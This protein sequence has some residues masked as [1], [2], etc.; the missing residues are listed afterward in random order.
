MR[1]CAIMPKR[2]GGR[3]RFRARQP[4]FETM[5]VRILL[6]AVFWTG[7]AGDN[8]WDTPSNWSTDAV[9]G[10][11]DDVAINVAADVVHPE[12]VVDTVNSLN[13]NQP[14]TISAGTL[15]VTTT[16]T[17]SADLTISGGTLDGAGDMTVGGLLTLSSGTLSGSGTVTANGGIILNGNFTATDGKTL[18]NPAGQTAS[19]SGIYNQFTLLDGAVIINDGTF[20]VQSGEG[21]V[22]SDG[23]TGAPVAF[24]NNGAFLYN[25]SGQSFSLYNVPFNVTSPG[26]VEVQAGTLQIGAGG[27][28][29]TSSGGMFAADADGTL[30]FTGGT[31]S[32]DAS[33]SIGGPGAVGFA[34]TETIA[35]PYDVTGT[36]VFQGGT[37][38]FSG[39]IV[40][41][42][43]TVMALGG[44]ANLGANPIATTTLTIT[45]GTLNGSAD[46][47]VGG[48]TTFNGNGDISGSGTITA[49][50]GIV[51]TNGLATIDGKTLVNP[52][53]QTAS[54]TG[55]YDGFTLLDGAV[56]VNDGTFDGQTASGLVNSEGN[57][58]AP[59]A[60]T[61][62]GA[63]LYNDV[64][65]TFAI[66]NVLFNVTSTGTVEVQAGTLQIGAGGGGGTSSGGMF[67][68]DADGTLDFTGGTYSLDASSSIGGPGAVGFAGTETI[69][70][71]YDVTGTTVFQGGTANFSG[72]IVAIGS[73][74]MALGGTANLGANPIDPAT[75]TVTNGT[76]NGSGDITVNGLTT[77]NGSGD[78]SG[79][80]T[81][82]A[83]GGIDLDGA[84]TTIDGKT[85]VNPA[86]Q[87]ASLT[88]IY[89]GFNLLDGAVIVN[90]GT[91]NVQSGAGTVE[92][93]GN[94]GARVAFTNNGVF[95]YNDPGQ[96]FSINNVPFNVTST[97]TV[98]VQAGTLR[99][100]GGGTETG[101][102]F[103]IDSGAVLD[104]SGG[105]ISTYTF[106]SSTSLVGAGTLS[107]SGYGTVVT[108]SSN[109]PALTGPTDIVSATLLVDGSQTNS[110]VTISHG[111]L[112]GTGTVGP[113]TSSGTI[114]PGTA[115]AT[116]ILNVQ[117]D[118]TMDDQA[119]F[120]VALQGPDAGT[121][122]DQLAVAGT[123]DITGSA[124]VASVSS[125]TPIK[126]EMFTIL[127]STA[128]TI[129]TFAGLPE[130]A[131]LVIDQVPFT[132]S[133]VGGSSGDD[134]VL[135]Q[136]D[137]TSTTISS[138]VDPSDVGEPVVFTAVVIAN[139]GIGTPTG[140]VTF[141]IDGDPQ[142]PVPLTVVNGQD[143]AS[144]PAVM[145]LSKGNHVITAA[146]R[147][148]DIFVDSTAPP[149][150]Q[151][152]GTIATTTVLASSADPSIVGQSLFFTATVASITGAVP[153]GTVTFS[154]DGQAQRQ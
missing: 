134:I 42:G 95:L 86:G 61:N 19:L 136:F 63:F 103:T 122:Y 21:T 15:S 101:A 11:S 9:P 59:V 135:T 151:S 46:I 116:G 82:G 114:N 70:A 126:H 119:T 85:L 12:N 18:V 131:A 143:E 50:G 111:I 55:N 78:L 118:V 22:N 74:V 69:A 28:G 57:I 34:G 49:G 123:A 47:T 62:N 31:Y 130:G 2:H 29:G 149:F 3:A 90:D 17:T 27:G 89:D 13:S 115:P 45:N 106:D 121:G 146:Y 145:N 125:F 138:S 58:G 80:G 48:L 54:L 10:S 43:S 60:F 99:L 75:L 72:P 88:G 107:V 64:G 52:A 32:L 97:G 94:T 30:D 96:S 105:A 81:V 37:A 73:A 39:P 76:L 147:G 137:P 124:L 100:D 144:L 110:A 112:G 24:I 120:Q 77:F 71:P 14:L 91:F 150:I 84:L 20:N 113:V 132:I 44:T 68:A 98:E 6:S 53:G 25:D 8:N 56:I 93:E 148:D 4:R 40:A 87:T 51:L 133:Y 79:S 7:T 109:N 139:V 33:S 35:A 41:V 108:I 92:S 67:A 5:E 152:V 129:G 142:D 83:D 65:Q 23:N 38:N 154:I 127:T 140:T 1:T 36:T 153:T 104:L 66:S 128:P 102:A 16:S 26:T 141:S 117:G